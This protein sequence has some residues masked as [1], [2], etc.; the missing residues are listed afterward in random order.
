MDKPDLLEDLLALQYVYGYNSKQGQ[1]DQKP[2]CHV[3][4]KSMDFDKLEI[5][6]VCLRCNL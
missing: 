3:C 2:V 6:W 4:G 1:Q 5:K